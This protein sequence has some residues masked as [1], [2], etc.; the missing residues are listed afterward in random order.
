MH[1]VVPS[2]C[3]CDLTLSYARSLVF[4]ELRISPPRNECS[5]V[6]RVRVSRRRWR[7]DDDVHSTGPRPI[8][9]D[10]SEQ[11]DAQRS[12][13]LASRL[14]S[15]PPFRLHRERL[16]AEPIDDSVNGITSTSVSCPGCGAQVTAEPSHAGDRGMLFE[17]PACGKIFGIVPGIP[18]VQQ[19]SSTQSAGGEIPADRLDPSQANEGPP[20]PEGAPGHDVAGHQLAS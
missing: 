12:R 6:H 3:L 16:M 20:G 14:N 18:N 13:F 19:G 15:Q 11:S 8:C 10:A 17:C 2:S 5:V 1:R 9:P 4:Q 7:G